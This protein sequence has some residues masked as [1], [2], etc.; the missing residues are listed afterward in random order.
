MR[1]LAGLAFAFATPALAQEGAKP[2]SKAAPAKRKASKPAKPLAARVVWSQFTDLPVAGDAE[3][4]LRY[5]GKVDAY[6]DVAGSAFG[7]DDSW[8]LHLHPEF[9]YGESANG[10]VGLLPSNTELFYPD[11][12]GEAF[13]LSVNLTKTWSSGTRLTVGKVNVLDLAAKL[14]VVGG[15]GH[16]GFQNLGLAL[17][18]SAIVPGSLTGAMLAV[19]TRKALFRLWVFDP[20][21]Q[22]QRSGLE[23]PF[24]EGVGF[25]GSV[26]FPVKVGG[27]RGY[28]AL[29]LAGSTRDSVAADALP[30]ALVPPP[31]SRF[32]NRKGEVSAVLAAYQYIAEYPEQPGA[33]IGVFAQVYLSNGDPTFLDRSGFIGISGNPRARPQDRFGLTY[34]HYSLADGLVDTLASRVALEDEEGIEAFYTLQVADPLR[35]TADVQVV[36]PAIAAR[37]LGVIGSL[38]FTATF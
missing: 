29:K 21:T 20:E 4:T 7:A 23:D 30:P 11:S 25:L 15:G 27:R 24:S 38:R 22:S 12:E 16:E 31:G 35:V 10:L 9:R 8:K 2:A 37:D 32:G 13:D 19:P 6:F 34:F 18:P 28:Y 36:D 14:P 26:T 33:G 5:G 1:V 17:P 3:P